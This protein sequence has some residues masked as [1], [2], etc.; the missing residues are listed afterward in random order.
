MKKA[1]EIETRKESVL[2]LIRNNPS[3]SKP[4]IARELRITDRQVRTV[5]DHLKEAGKIYYEGAGRGGRWIIN[6]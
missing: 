1:D 6:E 3:I 4:A 5:L 2:Y